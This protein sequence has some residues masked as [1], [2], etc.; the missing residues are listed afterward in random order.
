MA[1]LQEVKNLA[2]QLHAQL[3]IHAASYPNCVNVYM[4]QTKTQMRKNLQSDFRLFPYNSP[5]QENL[6]AAFEFM[7]R[8]NEL[9]YLKETIKKKEIQ[10]FVQTKLAT[11]DQW[12]TKALLK[13][14]DYQTASEKATDST[15]LRNCVGFSGSDAELLSSFAKQFQMKQWLSNKQMAIVRK[16]M[17]KYWKQIIDI[18]DELLLLRQVKAARPASIQLHLQLA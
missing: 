11:S 14:F 18:S 4:P 17:K 3:D 7:K 1:T 9:N 16:R 6:D 10:I 12:A 15:T 8:W 13:I 5:L 2:D